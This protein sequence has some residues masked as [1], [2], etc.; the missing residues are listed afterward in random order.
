MV[1]IYGGMALL[2]ISKTLQVEILSQVFKEWDTK[3]ETKILVP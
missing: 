3:I 2:Y 1:F